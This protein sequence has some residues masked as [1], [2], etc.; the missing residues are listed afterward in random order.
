MD[1]F[2]AVNCTIRRLVMNMRKLIFSGMIFV[3][4]AGLSISINAQTAG[5]GDATSKEY[6][7][8]LD[9]STKNADGSYSS[10]TLDPSKKPEDSY[11]AKF[12]AIE[13]IQ[14]LMKENLEQI[15][16]LKVIVSN[17][18]E[19]PWGDGFKK[20]YEGYKLA[21]ELYYRRNVIYARL[22]FENNRKDISIL[23]EIIAKEYRK[24][25]DDLL[26]NCAARIM[27]LHLNEQTK[28]DPNKTEELFKNQMRLRISYGQ[29]DDGIVSF[30]NK[31]FVS[32]ILHYRVAK[33]YAIKILEDLS[34]KEESE[35]LSKDM[36]KV[37]ADNLNRIFDVSDNKDTSGT[38]GTTKKTGP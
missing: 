4:C 28:S 34:K 17:N 33:T 14:L 16:L 5:G 35:K 8:K 3:L 30:D 11:L 9:D 10:K 13:V 24:E 21:M 37:K 19:K 2:V 18:K 36:Q 22:N 31:N 26:S 15:Y 29:L 25:T 20:A 27:E 12:H 1:A 32:S 6:K 23:L 38:G 7:D